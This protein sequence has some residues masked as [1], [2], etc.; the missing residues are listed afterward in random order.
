MSA[1]AHKRW[2][3]RTVIVAG[4]AVG[5]YAVAFPMQPA[6]AQFVVVPPPVVVYGGWGWAGPCWGC[7]PFFPDGRFFFRGNRVFFR[8]GHFFV[9]D[10]RFSHRGFRGRGF[11]HSGF[12][13]PRMMHGGFGGPGFTRGGFGSPGFAGGGMR[14]AMMGGGMGGRR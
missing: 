3:R 13:G 2:F 7:G 14:G 6:E 8:N 5:L 11:A 4:A 1:L 10:G 9:H 12:G